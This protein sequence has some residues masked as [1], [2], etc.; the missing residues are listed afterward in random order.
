MTAFAVDIIL[1]CDPLWLRPNSRNIADQLTRSG[2]STASNY[3]VASRARSRR[4]FISKISIA[5]EEADESLGWLEV[6]LG[7]G[8]APR[9]QVQPLL[10][11]CEELVAILCA[12]RTTAINRLREQQELLNRQK[13]SRR[14]V[15]NP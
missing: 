7:T 2:T 1:L 15:C 9:E 6:I 13:G 5:L 4:E 12:S 14:A 10:K 11:E 3:R 8:K